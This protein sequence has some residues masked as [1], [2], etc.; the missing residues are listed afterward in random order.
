MMIHRHKMKRT[1]T[2]TGK[3]VGVGSGLGANKHLVCSTLIF[4][5]GIDLV[6]DGT[7]CQNHT[8][9]LTTMATQS[10]MAALSIHSASREGTIIG[11]V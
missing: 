1:H 5:Y 6:R 11:K 8:P 9:F 10:T 2:H 4:V 3:H 7:L